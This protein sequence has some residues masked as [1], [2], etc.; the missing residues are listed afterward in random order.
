ME[1][2]EIKKQL[3]NS[4]DARFQR[5]T[6]TVCIGV[7]AFFCVVMA[8]L[9]KVSPGT[10]RL[11]SCAACVV[12][13]PLLLWRLWKLA[14]IFRNAEQ[15]IFFRGTLGSPRGDRK[16]VSFRVK[17]PDGKL[18]RTDKLFYIRNLQPLLSDWLDQTVTVAWNRA[19]DTVVVI[20][21]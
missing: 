5:R 7:L 11:M 14:R 4:V 12:L 13:L 21:R 3:W 10:V 1:L 17:T 16:A 18:R 9:W 6:L 19:T 2:Q 20:G 8:L 15:Y